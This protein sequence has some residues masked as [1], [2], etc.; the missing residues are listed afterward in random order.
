MPLPVAGNPP[1]QLTPDGNGGSFYEL[2]TAKEIGYISRAQRGRI[3]N[4]EIHH[5]PFRIVLPFQT[6]E[7]RTAFKSHPAPVFQNT[8]IGRNPPDR[9]RKGE[10]NDIPGFPYP[11]DAQE[12]FFH[13]PVECFPV[14][15]HM[16]RFICIVEIPVQT[17][18]H[19]LS[20]RPAG[21]PERKRERSLSCRCDFQGDH[22]FP[23][24]VPLLSHGNHP[25]FQRDL[26]LASGKQVHEQRV[27]PV[28]IDVPGNGRNE[29]HNVRRAAGARKPWRPLLPP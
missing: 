27:L 9:H 1:V 2:H 11:A 17:G 25:G 28:G 6:E 16:H 19:R 4:H 7:Q 26:C 12:S 22:A 23:W 21:N 5:L 3:R 24:V 15:R 10:C 29:P 20:P 13:D 18:G 8:F 14:H